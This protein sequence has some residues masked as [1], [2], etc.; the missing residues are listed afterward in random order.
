MRA[1]SRSCFVG[2]LAIVG[3]VLMALATTMSSAFQLAAMTALI[4]GGTGNPQ[5]DPAYVAGVDSR[6]IQGFYP[7][8]TSTGL[9][10]PEEFWP[11]S[12]PFPAGLRAMTFDESV[13]VGVGILDGAI[14][15]NIDSPDDKVAGFGYSQ[16][17]RI[18]SI[19]KR[20]LATD[21]D[22]PSPD[23]LFFTVIGNPNRPNGGFL[24]RGPEWLR[25]PI[26]GVTFGGPTPTDTGYETLDFTRQY[27]GWSD[28]PT[29][30][31]NL[32]SDINS[33]L[34]IWYLHGDYL[35]PA[36][37]TPILQD[38]YGD[39]TYYLIPTDTLPLLMP[40]QR[41]PFVGPVIAATLDAPL[42]VL[43]EA[44]YDRTTSPGEPTGFRLL[45]IPNLIDLGVNFVRA[46]PTG[47]D[48]GLQELGFGRLFGTEVPGPYGVG[49]PPVTMDPTTN[50]QN[51]QLAAVAEPIKPSAPVA[52]KLVSTNPTTN[53]QN[54]QLAAVA[55]PIKPSAP[56]ATKLVSTN[57]T[58]NEQNQQ[59][60]AAAEP[61][62]PSAPTAA[63]PTVTRIRGPI[64]SHLP[65]V[66]D[67]APSIKRA[68]GGPSTTS[69]PTDGANDADSDSGTSS[70]GGSAAA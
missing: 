65:Q 34:G 60:A 27:D 18:V 52:T 47:L 58:T 42:R 69:K 19:D 41:L 10:T 67:L 44:G 55:E 53:E 70:P 3:T 28:T 21:P 22:A 36:A 30:P 31:L 26:L 63:R 59:L 33:A 68:F 4:M 1:V 17:A 40:L 56:V 20:N 8:Y 51:Q 23:Q 14:K 46:I 61:I 2:F 49:G 35:S 29:N 13:D 66:K 12:P 6:Y 57:P 50:E 38:E 39:T 24:A 7:G 54:Q 48:D 32:L 64:G 37:G 5:P 45:Y 15:D 25:I 9:T 11:V 43:V 62:K 16:S